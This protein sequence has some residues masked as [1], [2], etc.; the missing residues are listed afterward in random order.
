M[1]LIPCIEAKTEEG[2]N[3]FYSHF[4]LKA[5][6]FRF[7]TQELSHGKRNRRQ[8]GVLYF[9]LLMEAGQPLDD[10]LQ[11][12]HTLSSETNGIFQTKLNLSP[13]WVHNLH[14]AQK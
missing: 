3:S 11:D 7:S 13:G 6:C 2:L 14:A 1:L 8:R 5:A 12:F 9:S 4:I 10:V